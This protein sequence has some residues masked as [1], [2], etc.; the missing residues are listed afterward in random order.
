VP[1]VTAQAPGRCYAPP[2][3]WRNYDVV[4]VGVEG[5]AVNLGNGDYRVVFPDQPVRNLVR[6]SG[7]RNVVVVGGHIRID[8]ATA[9]SNSRFGLKIVEQTGRVHLEGLLIDGGDLTEGIQFKAPR[10]QAVVQNVRVG[11]LRGG[12][13]GLNHSDHLQI[14]GGLG[15]GRDWG[16]K[17]CGFTGDTSN[18]QG[19][20]LKDDT[21]GTSGAI[22]IRYAN[23]R[24][25]DAPVTPG[26]NSG[27][28]TAYYAGHVASV[29]YDPGTVWVDPNPHHKNGTVSNA[30][31]PHG[32]GLATD[33]HGTY[34]NFDENWIT[35]RV[36]QGNPPGGDY[37][38]A[39]SVG[40]GY[41]L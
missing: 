20:M 32:T 8:D 24:L 13:V 25:L 23:I 31:A 19:M 18:V 34:T 21:G 26:G 1:V 9:T 22:D 15:Q 41:T 39:G 4:R 38:P 40:I 17:V 11:Q 29:H 30:V 37:V 5:G 16:L 12:S 36:H 7:G 28:R 6:I 3:G 10:A 33:T 14:W 35:G 2:S 27:G